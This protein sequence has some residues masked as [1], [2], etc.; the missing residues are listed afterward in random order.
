MSI[1]L[2]ILGRAITVDTADLIWHWLDATRSSQDDSTEQAVQFQQLEQVIEL[3]GA[4]RTQQA[5]EQLRLYL[6]DNPSCTRGRLAAAAICLSRNQ[7]PGAIEQLNSV[8]VRQPSN[9]IALYAL[10]HC[11]ER[12]G[13]ECQAAEFYQDCLKF[14][15]YLEMP[16]Q[17]LAAIYFKNSQLEKTIQEYELLRS[18]RPDDMSTLLALG[19]LYIANASY[20][21][22]I[23]TFNTA[24]LIH[25]DNFGI[26]DDYV[27]QLI[28]DGQLHEALDRLD[29]LLQD[30]PD[31]PDLAL[32]RA[33]VLSAL[34]AENEAVSQYQDVLRACPDFLE[35]TIKL[36]TQY[37]QTNQEQLAA[38]QL[39]RAVEINDE[40]VDAYIGLATAQKLAGQAC[41]ALT[42]LSLAAAIQ[43]NSSLLF[44]ETA[45]LQFRT[46]IAEAMI[47]HS[48]P[49]DQGELL[50]AVINT[51][52]AQIEQHPL[53]PDLHYRFGLL[54]MG[55]GGG[56]GAIDAFRRA[57]EINPTF[58]RAR[59]KLAVCLLEAGLQ[60]AAIEQLSAPACLDKQTLELHYKTA[61]LYCDKSKFASS[62]TNLERQMQQNFT[63]SADATVNIFLVLQNLGLQDR[64]EAMWESL[65]YTTT[66]A[67]NMNHPYSPWN[68]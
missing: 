26:Q 50:A 37:L 48:G 13:K 8:Y 53:D 47:P 51:H 35:A 36:G 22:S 30:E 17:R 5:E 10:G 9:T 68:S 42:T 19:Y 67:I 64:A 38:Q 12:M 25:P 20:A 62:L 15:N 52:K 23:E 3:M 55:V 65:S 66:Q 6:F 4:G 31:R 43:P 63:N 33:D 54:I 59:S 49:Q 21:K 40:I 16:R 14:K 44:V 57:L 11:Y 29:Q 41:E 2:E 7:L 45:T 60:D 46:A 28:R 56:A 34:G 32:K 58:S 61:L 18:E 27:D 39:N 1:R 24:I